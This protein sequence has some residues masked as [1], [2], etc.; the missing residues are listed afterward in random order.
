MIF[1]VNANFPFI[2]FV[3][4]FLF[5]FYG[6]RFKFELAY[7]VYIEWPESYKTGAV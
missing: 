3:L 1:L 7:K 4:Q 5:L 6:C 2:R